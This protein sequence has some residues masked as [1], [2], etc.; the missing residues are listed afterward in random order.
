MNPLE[1]YAREKDDTA[2]AVFDGHLRLVDCNRSFKEAFGDSEGASLDTLLS[3]ME[4]DILPSLLYE[5]ELQGGTTPVSLA[6]NTESYR[7]VFRVE[8]FSIEEGDRKLLV[9]SFRDETEKGFMEQTLRDRNLSLATISPG[10]P[11]G[12][13]R[14]A[15]SGNIISVNRPLV[16]MLGYENEYDLFSARIPETWVDPS[17]RER[18]L[19]LLEKDGTVSGMEVQWKHRS[20]GVVWASISAYGLQADSGETQ[21]FDAVVLDITQRKLAEKELKQYRNRLQEMVAEKTAELSRANDM[22][23]MEVSERQKAETIQGVLHSITYAATSSKTMFRLLEEIHSHL[24]RLFHTPNLFFAFYDPADNSYSFP[25]SID[26]KDGAVGFTIPGYM[27]GTLTD[28]VRSS[29]EPLLI[30]RESYDRLVEQGRLREVGTVCQQWMGVPLKDQSGVWGV[31]AV[32]SYQMVNAYSEDD[33][34]LFEKMGEHVALAIS[35]H[36]AEQELKKNGALFQAVLEAE[37]RGIIVTDSDGIVVYINPV[38]SREMEIPP[39]EARGRELSG[40][41]HPEDHLPLAEAVENWKR[42]GGRPVLLRVTAG[43]CTVSARPLRDG[44]GSLLGLI[45]IEEDPDQFDSSDFTD[46]GQS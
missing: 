32:Q 36:R 16:D 8:L 23:L 20:G 19:H 22:L 44:S 43:P 15:R 17:E 26:E 18:L 13:F 42:G 46:S 29:G 24:S 27:E 2:L 45:A 25:Y 10:I 4:Q 35:R 41:L 37:R 38:L 40:I 12:F 9:A 6:L 31:L 11:V 7:R 33:L 21:V 14:A 28:L 1:L 3:G 34:G 5:I 30:D 39:E